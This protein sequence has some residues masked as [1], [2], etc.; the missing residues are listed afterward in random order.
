VW[1]VSFVTVRTRLQTVRMSIAEYRAA[2]HGPGGP[3][4]SVAA[5]TG[6]DPA[7]GGR[8]ARPV[9]ESRQFGAG[10]VDC[11]LREVTRTHRHS[12]EEQAGE[13]TRTLNNFAFVAKFM[14]SMP[15][16][17]SKTIARPARRR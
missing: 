6:S 17:Y 10:G 15:K 4:C 5:A 7:S 16:A 11:R 12:K 14:L 9:Y 8:L 2:G 13:G 3:P 1:G